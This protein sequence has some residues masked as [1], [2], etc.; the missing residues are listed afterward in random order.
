MS[1]RAVDGKV[2]LKLV[3]VAEKPSIKGRKLVCL[4]EAALEDA[5]TRQVGGFTM[6]M[7]GNAW[8]Q[9]VADVAGLDVADPET[10]AMMFAVT[11]LIEVL[12]AK[13]NLCEVF[14]GAV[15]KFQGNGNGFGSAPWYETGMAAVQREDEQG[16]VPSQD[17]FRLGP[18]LAANLARELEKRTEA[19]SQSRAKME[20]LKEAYV[21]AH[22]EWQEAN[23]R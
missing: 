20:Q 22:Q 19:E 8:R 18:R 12:L 7:M 5:W 1:R 17:C 9:G 23:E 11:M 14:C 4:C 6:G 21:E 15:S 10:G 13:S 3:V 2:F 16:I